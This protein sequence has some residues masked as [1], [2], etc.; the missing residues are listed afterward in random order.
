MRTIKL[1]I[2]TAP[3]GVADRR[4]LK[5]FEAAGL[6]YRVNPHGR[7]LT[8]PELSDFIKDSTVLVAGTEPITADTMDAAPKLQLIA[9][10]G[11]GLDNVD[12]EAA[13]RRG[14]AVTY[15]PDAPTPGVAEL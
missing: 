14:I 9:R 12:L 3:F 7:R 11:I 8:G 5:L 1:F 10:V 13:R 15:T 4:S 2:S 6:E